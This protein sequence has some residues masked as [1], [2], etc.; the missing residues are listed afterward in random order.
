MILFK[1]YSKED[2]NIWDTFIDESKNGTFMLKR[3]FIEYHSD[4]F[5]DYSLLILNDSKLIAVLP[6]SIHGSE[7]R[8]HGGLTY[9]G[10]IYSRKMTAQMMVE[11][12]A[13]LVEYLKQHDVSSLIY[14][15]VPAIYNTYP[16]DEDLYAL[17]RINAELYRRDISTSI[18][19]PDRIAFN[20]RR[21][22]NIK[23]AIKADLE[24]RQSYDYTGYIE[25][26]TDVLA[27]KHGVRPVHTGEELE[28][29]ASNFPENIKLYVAVSGGKMIAGTLLFITKKVVHSQYIA[30]SQEGKMC[31]ALDF[32]FDKLI[33]DVF[34]DFTYFDFGIS[35]EEEGRYLNEG[36]IEQKQEFGGRATVYDFYKIDIN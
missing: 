18:Y 14:K 23:K 2:K 21:R 22:R 34:S 25:M 1:K 6:A 32:V 7:V 5:Q 27:S 35:T 9:G 4:R 17:F 12:L 11:I 16:A 10:I 26:L 19:L 20:E 3:D 28:Y 33:N 13:S 30:N 36:L 8:S 31:G 29:L 24:F 15:R